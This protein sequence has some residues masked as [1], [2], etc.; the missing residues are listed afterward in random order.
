M[1]SEPLIYSEIKLIVDTELM[2]LHSYK[3]I[4]SSTE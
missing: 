2:K 3:A 4:D 1:S